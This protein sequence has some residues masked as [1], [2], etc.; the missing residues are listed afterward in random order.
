MQG[1]ISGRTF[2]V[3]RAVNK[4]G[5]LLMVLLTVFLLLWASTADARRLGGGGSFGRQSP[6]VTNRSA[7]QPTQRNNAQNQRQT[8][9]QQAGQQPRKPWGGMLG[10]LA[11]G[12]GLAALFHW[13]GF[14]PVLG[15]M[16]GTLLL[17]LLAFAAIT[18]FMRMMRRPAQAQQ[19]AG[20]GGPAAGWNQPQ[21][22]PFQSNPATAPGAWDGSAA[23][24]GSSWGRM[25]IPAGFDV[26]GFEEVAKAN[27]VR[28]QKA[29]DAG[30]VSSLKAFLT[31]EMYTLMKGQLAQRHN[32]F[33]G[34]TN[35]TDVVTLNAQLL[36]IEEVGSEYMASVEF[37]G[38]IRENP[39]A[40]AEPFTEV[41]NLTKDKAAAN[42][43][44][45]LAGI[46]NIPST[47]R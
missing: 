6:S 10:G 30:D 2:P 44:W 24:A 31:D 32:D 28:L 37:S 29:W 26:Q 13:M 45:L 8:P 4:W 47:P 19:A 25:E 7:T 3:R 34:T 43:G 15:D 20:A 21:A 46:Q 42:G 22:T 27:F 9:P 1:V 5:R 14:G 33:S 16:L 17:V 36:G 35:Q 23:T 38:M 40:G 18:F 12:L 39:T 41:W 11:A